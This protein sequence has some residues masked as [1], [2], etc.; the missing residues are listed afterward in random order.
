M[1]RTPVLLLLAGAGAL[2]LSL[3]GAAC[4]RD[5][6]RATTQTTVP[7][8]PATPTPATSALVMSPK[9]ENYNLQALAFTRDGKRL[10]ADGGPAG[11]F[12]W[13]VASGKQLA[14][15]GNGGY[16]DVSVFG[17]L[18]NGHDVVVLT[19][20]GLLA[21]TSLDDGKQRWF[22]PRLDRPA[23][24]TALA[25]APD[26]VNGVV[27]KG[28]GTL[29]VWDIATHTSKRTFAARTHDIVTRVEY[30]GPDGAELITAGSS[31]TP[32]AADARVR[33]WDVKS[34]TIVSTFEGPPENVA[35]LAVTPD[36]TRAVTVSLDASIRV[37]DVKSG[38]E[39]QSFDLAN[40]GEAFVVRGAGSGVRI[41]RDG[42]RVLTAW[43]GSVC[44]WDVASRSRIACVSTRVDG[45]ALSPDD[46]FVAYS[47]GTEVVVRPMET[48]G[49]GEDG[50]APAPWLVWPRAPTTWSVARGASVPAPLLASSATTVADEACAVLALLSGDVSTK[51]LSEDSK[52]PP[53]ESMWLAT[54]PPSSERVTNPD[55]IP[56]ADRVLEIMRRGPG[57]SCYAHARDANP[58]V[59]GKL[60]FAI[61]V[62]A[63]G[64]VTTVTARPSTGG[65]DQLSACV[66]AVLH[67]A[68][69]DAPPKGKGTIHA[70][71]VFAPP[72]K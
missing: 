52:G 64:A 46:R 30:L 2:S 47:A 54:L 21:V 31:S 29:G 42:R 17:E 5:A 28:D 37:W 56:N 3:G 1:R 49:A 70:T 6:S 9:S 13:D 65:L 67:R 4:R 44:A 68:S 72:G 48:F 59:A 62:D 69:F 60:T 7:P 20:N 18:A 8:P 61:N 23:N 24:I 39:L 51:R 32:E 11:F 43:P 58:E 50:G 63:N 22:L 35:H 25:L 36:G 34:G 71:F 53:P 66:T 26:G 16:R 57:R 55:G 38:T 40:Q 14:A 10:Y 27:A 45:L 19:N 12:V 41:T 15:L 33:V